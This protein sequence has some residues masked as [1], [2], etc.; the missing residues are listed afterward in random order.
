MRVEWDSRKAIM[1]EEQFDDLLPEY[2]LDYRKA[3]PNRFGVAEQQR[4]V[5]LEPDVA[6]YF[7][8]SD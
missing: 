7:H 2:E 8:D 6:E 3:K 1:D 5:I 4:V